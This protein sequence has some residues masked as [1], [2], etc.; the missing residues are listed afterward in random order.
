MNPV[1]NLLPAALILAMTGLAYG[2]DAPQPA[3]PQTQ[4]PSSGS[5]MGHDGMMG[6]R[7]TGSG[8]MGP[9]MMG[10]EGPDGM[11]CTM[12]GRHV[13]GRLAF[14]KTELKITADQ[15]PLWNAYADAARANAK[16]MSGRC[17]TMMGRGTEPATS[18]PDRLDQHEQVMSAHLDALRA[19]NKALKPLY[20][21]LTTEQ[22]KEFD[23]IGWGPM[24]MM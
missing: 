24:G 8:M 18:L 7:H 1:R 6:G 3:S 10:P 19:M 5:M 11:M 16:A 12:M 13:E 4:A 17:A 14:I 15:E 21:A 22:K 9:G 23:E 20:A 2:A